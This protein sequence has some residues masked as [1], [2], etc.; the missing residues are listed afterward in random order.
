LAQ[1]ELME[2]LRSFAEGGGGPKPFSAQ[3]HSR[4]LSAPDA[5]A[6]KAKRG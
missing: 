4:F 6:M 5:A 3:D 2:H 1:R